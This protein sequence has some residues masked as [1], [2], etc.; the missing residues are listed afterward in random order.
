MAAHR[1]LWRYPHLCV[2]LPPPLSL[3]PPICS[4]TSADFAHSHLPSGL[5][6]RPVPLA[7][8]APRSGG[9]RAGGCRRAL[10]AGDPL[11]GHVAIPFPHGCC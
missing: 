6:L 8:R 1:L 9:V 4:P 10:H 2:R 5:F 7:S 3:S 11:L